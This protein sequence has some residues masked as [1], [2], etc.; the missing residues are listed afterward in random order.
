MWRRCLLSAML[1]QPLSEAGSLCFCSLCWDSQQFLLS[2][3]INL[4][5]NLMALL[6]KCCREFMVPYSAVLTCGAYLLSIVA[7]EDTRVK[8]LPSCALLQHERRVKS[9]F[10]THNCISTPVE[11]NGLRERTYG[12]YV[13]GQKSIPAAVV[14]GSQRQ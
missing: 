5:D 12:G 13:I 7:A 10:E 1:L 14:T 4:V 6:P 8:T 11:I 9:V 3:A 2:P